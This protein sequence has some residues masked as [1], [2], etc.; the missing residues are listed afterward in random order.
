MDDG[1][2]RGC[3]HPKPLTPSHVVHFK[4]GS[5][6]FLRCIRSERATVLCQIKHKDLG[7]RTSD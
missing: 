1:W 6:S 4:Y 2:H 7:I 3:H 5:Y